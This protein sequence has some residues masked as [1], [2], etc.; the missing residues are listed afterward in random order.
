MAAGLPVVASRTGQVAKLIEDGVT[1][2]LYEPGDVSALV[3]ALD[4]LRREPELRL[5]LGRAARAS[6][7]RG[8]TWDA[9]VQ[10]ILAISRRELPSGGARER[11]AS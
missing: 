6:V 5:T 3:A 11:A 7:L 2:L 4:R 1:G 10:H 8:H 9:I